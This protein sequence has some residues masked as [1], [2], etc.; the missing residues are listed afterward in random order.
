MNNSRVRWAN[1]T[2]MVVMSVGND[3]TLII[4]VSRNERIE[5][6]VQLGVDTAHCFQTSGNRPNLQFEIEYRSFKKEQNIQ[7][8]IDVA[9]HPFFKG[10]S[11][12]VYCYSK[13]QAEETQQMLEAKGVTAAFYHAGMDPGARTE[14][15]DKWMRNDCQVR[16]RMNNH[17]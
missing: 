4:F 12:I 5:V 16:T 13:F 9:T 14:A 2:V 8:I 6:R 3:P 17:E 1:E 10:R 7:R 15:Q 11:G